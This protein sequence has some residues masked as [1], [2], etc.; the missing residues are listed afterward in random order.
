MEV[1]CTCQPRDSP[2]EVRYLE[3]DPE[4]WEPVFGKDHAQTKRA[5]ATADSIK[6]DWA[7]AAMEPITTTARLAEACAR[8]AQHPYVTVD[9]EFLRETT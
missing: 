6:L 7:L 2:D 1:E 5:R 4:K 3:H 9:T 8:L